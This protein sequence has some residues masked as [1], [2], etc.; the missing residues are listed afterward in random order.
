MILKNPT[1]FCGHR[2]SI[3]NYQFYKEVERIL[4]QDGRIII[5]D[6]P[7]FNKKNIFYNFINFLSNIGDQRDISDINNK[8]T[9][10]NFTVLT[11]EV[12]DI[13]STITLIIADKKSIFSQ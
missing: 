8:L 7:Q 5:V 9:K 3:L 1:K 4:Q 2:N 13:I 6:Y 11:K 10:L 12:Q